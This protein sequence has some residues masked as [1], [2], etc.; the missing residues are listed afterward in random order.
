[1]PYLEAKVGTIAAGILTREELE[2]FL[3]G[4]HSV[5]VAEV[6]DRI[7]KFTFILILSSRAL[8]QKIILI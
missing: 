5:I 4:D 2:L 1:M 7:V 6:V 3:N 8:V